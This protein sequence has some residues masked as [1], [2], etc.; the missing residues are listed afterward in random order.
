MLLKKI[1]IHSLK[2]ATSAI[3]SDY[4]RWQG[5]LQL[6]I[7][8]RIYAW[9]DVSF[10]V[11]SSIAWIFLPNM[12]PIVKYF[13][14]ENFIKI[15]MSSMV[16]TL[17]WFGC[18]CSNMQLTQLGYCERNLQVIIPHVFS[19][20]FSVKHFSQF[21]EYFSFSTICFDI[22]ISE[23][24]LKFFWNILQ[25]CFKNISGIR[26]LEQSCILFVTPKVN[27]VLHKRHDHSEFTPQVTG[28]QL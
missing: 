15:K 14:Q 10:L 17:Q 27:M 16:H 24:F 5:I 22:W 21:R 13:L 3:Q 1:R 11:V 28:N 9:A 20:S 8:V 25:I 19:Y 4:N 2:V 6:A 12:P 26:E 23:S 7:V 18:L